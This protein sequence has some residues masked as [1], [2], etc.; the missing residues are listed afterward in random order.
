LLVGL[1]AGR[2]I[3]ESE[4]AMQQE[5]ARVETRN[6]AAEKASFDAGKK[7]TG[8]PSENGG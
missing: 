1:G 7:G 2:G 4:G 6:E 3:L 8:N 5:K